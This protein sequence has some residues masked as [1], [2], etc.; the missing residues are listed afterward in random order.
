MCEAQL[1]C[2][3]EGALGTGMSDVTNRDGLDVSSVLTDADHREG[4]DINYDSITR[5]CTNG[6]RRKPLKSNKS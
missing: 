3:E 1:A 2:M 5:I 4:L 6:Y